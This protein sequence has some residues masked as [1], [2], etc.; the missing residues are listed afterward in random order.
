[1]V[2]R[3]LSSLAEH[4]PR[5]MGAAI[6]PL[7]LFP[8]Q[9]VLAYIVHYLARTRPELF[10]R[11]G[12]HV[13][14]EYLIDVRELPFVFVLVPDPAAPKLWAARR[15]EV[16]VATATI[17]G[18][19]RELFRIIDGRGDSDALFFSRDIRIG[20]NTEAAVCLR[21]AFDDLEGSIV[22]DLVDPRGPLPPPLRFVLA[23][24]RRLDPQQEQGYRP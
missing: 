12:H 10:E 17:S 6:A 8:V 13:R 14:S 20:G 9:L 5:L 4:F 23:Q 16:P 21:N 7:P 22:D 11:L 1:M 3:E 2:T 19:F 18:S 24:L 15:N